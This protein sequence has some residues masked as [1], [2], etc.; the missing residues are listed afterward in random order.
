ML[1]LQLQWTRVWLK[2]LWT[3]LVV[4]H[5]TPWFSICIKKKQF[6][7]N[8]I[9]YG[10]TLFV[11]LAKVGI[12]QL[13]HKQWSNVWK[14]QHVATDCIPWQVMVYQ[15]QVRSGVWPPVPWGTAACGL[16]ALL[17]MGAG[18]LRVLGMVWN[19][20]ASLIKELKLWLSQAMLVLKQISSLG[21]FHFAAWRGGCEFLTWPKSLA[22]PR[23][24]PC[25]CLFSK[26]ILME[27][28]A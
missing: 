9:H 17:V 8:M 24:N 10:E 6:Q 21:D 1:Q 20:F 12:G 26:W 22:P 16:L 5:A 28:L 25:R 19:R 23:K 3:H 7:K 14:R 15:R 18:V 27:S 2:S 11:N 4:M 13:C